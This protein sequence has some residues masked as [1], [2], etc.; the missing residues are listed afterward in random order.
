M[1]TNPPIYNRNRQIVSCL[2]ADLAVFN[3]DKNV[4]QVKIKT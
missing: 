2:H 4:L 1:K 3:I